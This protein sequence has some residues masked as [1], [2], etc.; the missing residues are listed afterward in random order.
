MTQF[1]ESTSNPRT[2]GFGGVSTKW[3]RNNK[4]VVNVVAT[5]LIVATQDP[6]CNRVFTKLNDSYL[7]IM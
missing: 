3:S 5:P 6:Q 1:E 7:S 2:S 4:V